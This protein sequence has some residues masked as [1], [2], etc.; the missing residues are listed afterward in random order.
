MWLYAFNVD[1][2][3]TT[4]QPVQGSSAHTPVKHTER[5]TDGKL[6]VYT[7]VCMNFTQTM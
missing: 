6:H 4:S 7:Y 2:S 5:A 1:T 3:E